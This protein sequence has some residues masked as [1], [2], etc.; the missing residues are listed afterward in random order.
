MEV[1]WLD[2]ITDSVDMSLSKLREL[3]I[4]KT[5]W[6]AAVHGVAKSQTRLSNWT[7]LNVNLVWTLSRVEKL[8]EEHSRDFKCFKN[9]STLQPKQVSVLTLAHLPH[10]TASLKTKARWEQGGVTC[11]RSQEQQSL[12]FKLFEAVLHIRSI[13]VSDLSVRKQICSMSS[14]SPFKTKMYHE[15]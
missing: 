10:L 6:H 7:E 5:A 4:D 11:S 12:R 13:S 15:P 3:V 14:L 8:L 1:R 2:G 9:M